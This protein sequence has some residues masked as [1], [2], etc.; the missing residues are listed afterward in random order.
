MTLST[1]FSASNQHRLALAAALLLAISSTSQAAET[2]SALLHKLKLATNEVSGFDNQY[3]AQVWLVAK[4]RPLAR[5]IKDPAQRL[6]MLKLIH[7]EA[8]RADL[9]PEI[10]LALIEV[11]SAFDS[12]AVSVAGAQGMMQVMPFWKKELGRPEDN[13]I[14]PQTNLR[15]GCTILKHYLDREQGRLADALAR[16]NGSYGQYWYAERVL[17]T[18]DLHWR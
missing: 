14:N 3:D 8:R 5:I 6:A 2:D 10:V 17:D 13:L 7:S 11:E 9:Q 12:Y 16:Y 4:D 15:Y 1:I 18:W